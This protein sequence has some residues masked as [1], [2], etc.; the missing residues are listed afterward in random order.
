MP[1]TPA[2]HLHLPGF[3]VG[4]TEQWALAMAKVLPPLGWRL[5]ATR[6]EVSSSEVEAAFAGWPMLEVEAI[7]GD[8]LIVAPWDFDR[9][10]PFRD[11]L[12]AVAHGMNDYYKSILR[13][14]AYARGVAVAEVAR[15]AF[16][17]GT[18]IEV[19]HNGVDPDR[20]VPRRS[21]AE[22][23]AAL[24]LPPEALVIGFVG[25]WGVGKNPLAIARAAAAIPGAVALYVGPWEEQPA[26]S[27]EAATLAPCRFVSPAEAIHIGDFYAAMDVCVIASRTEGFSLVAVE[28]WLSGVPLVSTPVGVVLEH[29]GLTVELPPDPSADAMAAAVH[30]AIDPSRAPSIGEAERTAEARYTVEAMGRRWRVYLQALAREIA[31]PGA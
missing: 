22:V 29:P 11:R 15:Q 13:G 19:I 6:P 9:L 4:G 16:P 7:P 10:A 18:T 28:A 1:N 26:L 14:G 17:D 31:L 25:R 5:S 20:L 30:A 21:R 24:G 8:A 23:R 2:L 3:T 12:V 27:A